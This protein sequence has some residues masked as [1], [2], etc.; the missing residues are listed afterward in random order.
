MAYSH[1]T[2][3]H[4]WAN[5]TGRK[6]TGFSVFYEGPVIYSYG[7]HF[8]VAAHV[9]TPSGEPLILFT[10]ASYSVST[11]KHKTIIRRAAGYDDSRVLQ[12]SDLSDLRLLSGPDGYATVLPGSMA[13]ELE[14]MRAALPEKAR[15]W[16]LARVYKHHHA[17]AM[18]DLITRHNR[19][20]DL[21][22][23][24]VDRLDMP[25]DI[26]AFAADYEAAQ[27]A[28]GE[29]RDARDADQIAAWLRGEDVAP[30]HT[31]IPYVRV[32]T[33]QGG[34]RVVQTS[35][36]VTVPLPQALAAYR[37]AKC[38]AAKGKAFNP[39]KPH[40]LGG[41]QLDRIGPDGTI[42]AGCHLI[43]ISVARKAARLAGL[44]A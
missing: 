30:P 11:S 34:H 14:R 29:A 32:Y 22:Q 17:S 39:G 16:K 10:G 5:M 38:C 26:A 40:S 3:A 8:P 42:K 20:A 33:A 23:L 28:E 15:K 25:E 24:D 36:G 9:L 19:L 43:P 44:E 18:Q 7:R 35:W 12:V 31:R 2:V 37:L 13:A 27:L 21:W 6:T 4:N 41:W 1:N